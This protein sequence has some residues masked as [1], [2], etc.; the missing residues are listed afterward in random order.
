M[1]KLNKRLTSVHQF[2]LMIEE[3]LYRF[4][5]YEIGSISPALPE[6]R[7]REMISYIK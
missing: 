1:A 3:Q 2:V 6:L 4:V 5:G 7:K